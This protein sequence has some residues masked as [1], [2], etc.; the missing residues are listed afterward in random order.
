MV[1]VS[2]CGM[3]RTADL[4]Q[5]PDVPDLAL[6]ATA[7]APTTATTPTPRIMPDTGD[8]GMYQMCGVEHVT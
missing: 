6:A 1:C 8:I 7:A 3:W 4:P 5:S 2:M